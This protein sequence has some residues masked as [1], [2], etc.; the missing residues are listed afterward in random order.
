MID[1]QQELNGFQL[2]A[3]TT[4]EGPVMVIAGPGSGKTR[5]LTYRIAYMLERG[6]APWNIL[7]LTFTNKAA[8]EMK[9]RLERLV[10]PSGQ[11][12]WAGTFHSIFA[13]ILRIESQKLGYPSTFTIYDTD[14]SKSLI[15]Q[16]VKE[17][18]LDKAVYTSNLIRNRISSAKSMLISP[19]AYANN[20]DLI[21]EDKN[22]NVPLLFRIYGQYARRCF[23]SGVMDFDDL[24]Y[25]FFLLL[26]R[27]P[28]NVLEKYRDKFKY[29]LVD[30]FQ[31]TNYLQYAILKKLVRYPGSP[32]NICI[33]GDDAQ[34]I[35]A[36][37][38]ATIDNI[39]DFEKEFS[40]VRVVK[41]EQNY[42]SSKYIIDAA[43][44]VINHNAQQIKKKI[45]TDKQD[46]K[47]I[48]VIRALTDIE[49]ARKVVDGIF[50][51]KNRAHLPNSEIAILYRTNAQSR[52]FEEHL[53]RNNMPYRIYGG[54]SFYQRKEVK[55]LL[56]YFRLVVNPQDEEALRR[57]INLPKRG[58][59]DTTLDKLFAYAREHKITAWEAMTHNL[60]PARTQA[61]LYEF[62][63]TI[64]QL[65]QESQQV[66]V[67]EIANK[68]YLKS[69]LSSLYKNDSSPEGRA[70]LE[71]IQSLLDGIKEYVE[72]DVI[73][74]GEEISD[75]S[76]QEYLQ[77]IALLTDQDTETKDKDF[78]SLMSVHAAK[79]LEF[80]AVF[81]TG[82]EEK[83]F[84]SFM[85]L[86]TPDG[87]H[88]ER[89]LFFVA[90][91]RARY[92]LTLTY[93][94]S[95]F[96]FGKQ[97]YF[98]PSRFLDE[99]GD[100]NLRVPAH[101]PQ[102]IISERQQ[103]SAVSGNF[104]STKTAIPGDDRFKVVASPVSLFAT[105]QEVLHPRFGKGKIIRI[106]GSG[107][108]RIASVR[109]ALTGDDERR[110][111]LKFAKM[112]VLD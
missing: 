10:G 103:K 69:G 17:M 4:I 85:S 8:R 107:D 73:E 42:R 77:S 90:L 81:I 51:L 11:K 56:A 1:F 92:H 80:D 2:E 87:I 16:I 15:G 91:T 63:K 19:A 62:H 35:Y 45:W 55:D 109:F 43:N 88:E 93:A 78:I 99:V 53:R 86:D 5:V 7:A 95:R 112:E 68:I 60:F 23:D 22:R 84:P 72:N 111:M 50:E 18:N 97:A 67:D 104:K 102:N 31:D 21:E 70:R 79:G 28:E 74:F 41:L 36:F 39:L 20:P 54:M 66:M 98:Q 57:I 105:G 100:E 13:K 49:E 96:K 75:K 37:R 65:H 29:L 59:G 40:T 3:C 34:S 24:L 12:V 25:N 83:L 38:G 110:I 44:K 76:L 52:T 46:N 48:D 14:D 30:E 108:S 94:T 106:D 26:Q 101:K 89:R 61:L 64:N 71:N 27:N 32:E 9:D 58:L 6:I 82:L 33:V 47:K